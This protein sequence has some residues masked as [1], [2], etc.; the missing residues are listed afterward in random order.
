VTAVGGPDHIHHVAGCEGHHI[1][2]I[3]VYV[4]T[5]LQ[6]AILNMRRRRSDMSSWTHHEAIELE[7]ALDCI[8]DLI[9][10][11]LTAISTEK[12]KQAPDQIVIERHNGEVKSLLMR[13]RALGV[14]DRAEIAQIHQEYPVERNRLEEEIK[15]AT[16]SAVFEQ[17]KKIQ[18]ASAGHG[19]EPHHAPA[20]RCATATG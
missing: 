8:R 16:L 9:G 7:C 15:W 2:I 19:K 11:H 14:H 12:E 10:I 6:Y 5:I 18:E 13:Q 4:T 17:A 3:Y 1:D 20:S